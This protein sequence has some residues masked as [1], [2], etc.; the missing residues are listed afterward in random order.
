MGR[1]LLLFGL[2]IFDDDFVH[3]RTHFYE[4]R[5]I[6]M[7]LGAFRKKCV[8]REGREILY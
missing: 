1:A 6:Y 2:F 5:Q 3:F 7:P 8:D 4:S